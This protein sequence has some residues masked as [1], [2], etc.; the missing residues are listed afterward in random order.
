LEGNL[1]NYKF[2]KTG[3]KTEAIILPEVYG[4]LNKR[5]KGYYYEFNV[6]SIVYK[7]YTIKQEG[8]YPGQVIVVYYLKDD[9]TKNRDYLRVE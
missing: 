3:L 6:N 2:K 9:P 5:I 4:V 8:Y 1:L 7:G